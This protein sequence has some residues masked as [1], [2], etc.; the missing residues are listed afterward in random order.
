MDKTIAQVRDFSRG[1]VRAI[2]PSV[3]ICKQH[4][5]VHTFGYRR[6]LANGKS[7]GFSDND[8][9]NRVCLE[10]FTG[11]KIAEYEKDLKH[12]M[13]S[14]ETHFLRKGLPDPN[15]SFLK[16]LYATNVWNTLCLYRKNTQHNFIEAFFFGASPKDSHM[17]EVYMDQLDFIHDWIEKMQWRLMP[18]FT[19]KAHG[20]F[21]QTVTES[22]CLQSLEEFFLTVQAECCTNIFLSL[23]EKEREVAYLL[24]KGYKRRQIA[25][26]L[27][28]APKTVDANIEHIKAKT[29]C[30]SKRAF[31]KFLQIPKMQDFLRKDENLNSTNKCNTIGFKKMSQLVYCQPELFTKVLQ[32]ENIQSTDSRA[33]IPHCCAK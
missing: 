28:I 20:Y 10:H 5:G 23:S 18:F 19:E 22:A 12:Y 14:G 9:W 11:L 1:I 26:N 25:L 17:I 27:D 30:L 31:L 7:F 21:S 3:S 6:F 4:L 24:A 8:C 16:A 2:S 15:S 33:K 13:T 32:N 29:H